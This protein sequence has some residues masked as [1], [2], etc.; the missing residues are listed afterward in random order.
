MSPLQH[1]LAIVGVSLHYFMPFNRD[2]IYTSASKISGVTGNRRVCKETPKVNENYIRNSRLAIC[3]I[4][5]R[6]NRRGCSGFGRHTFQPYI[7]LTISFVAEQSPRCNIAWEIQRGSIW[8]ARNITGNISYIHSWKNKIAALYCYVLVPPQKVTRA[9]FRAA[10]RGLHTYTLLPRRTPLQSFA[11]INSNV[12]SGSSFKPI[13][14]H[15]TTLG[16]SSN[17]RKWC[18]SPKCWAEAQTYR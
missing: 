8:Y 13:Y 14:T 17:Y 1:W 3:T 16:L 11:V 2:E 7:A 6:R 12:S 5:W 18:S 10:Q 9:A 15:S 4:Q